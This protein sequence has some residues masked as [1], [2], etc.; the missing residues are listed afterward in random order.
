MDPNR[1]DISHEIGNINI[2]FSLK[3]RAT[4]LA[5][6]NT[7]ELRTALDYFFDDQGMAMDG[8]WCPPNGS[9]EASSSTEAYSSSKV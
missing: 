7:E 6:V 9:G 8:G 2:C 5:R 1:V 4:F 3:L